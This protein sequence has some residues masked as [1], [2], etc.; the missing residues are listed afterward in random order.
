[1]LPGSFT[2]NFDPGLILSIAS[3]IVS[4]GRLAV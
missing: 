4:F 2:F 1:M 3:L